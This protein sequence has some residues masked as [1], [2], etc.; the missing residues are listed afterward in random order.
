MKQDLSN[1]VAQ[2]LIHTINSYLSGEMNRKEFSIVYNTALIEYENEI[3]N[4]A[5]SPID[6]IVPSDKNS[7]KAW[8]LN[9]IKLYEVEIQRIKA[10]IKKPEKSYAEKLSEVELK[11]LCPQAISAIK[12][13]MLDVNTKK[14]IQE[15]IVNDVNFEFFDVNGR[16]KLGNSLILYKTSIVKES[17]LFSALDNSIQTSSISLVETL[18]ALKESLGTQSAV[19]SKCTS[20]DASHASIDISSWS[21][22]PL[23]EIERFLWLERES[24]QS[25]QSCGVLDLILLPEDRSWMLRGCNTF[26]EIFIELHGKDE[27][28]NMV[29]NRAKK[30]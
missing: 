21:D 1:K 8:K 13:Q 9:F 30:V 2:N 16:S 29:F 15:N 23:S 7:E 10:E 28:I 17:L 25:V 27:F 22:D 12:R 5:Y 20:P 14:W 11:S 24:S 3:G 6:T 26:E 18:K 4:K 19:W